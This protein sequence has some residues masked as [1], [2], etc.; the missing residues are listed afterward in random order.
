MKR[1]AGRAVVITGASR[2]LGRAMALA[3]GAEGAHVFVGYHRREDDAAETL[4]L[5]SGAGTGEALR[6]DVTRPE[7][8]DAAFDR[9]H[10]ARG[11]VDVL[12]NNAGS[13]RDAPVTLMDP[14]AWR[15]V[16]AVNLDGAFLCTRAALSP[17][18]HAR[19]GA[20]VN[21]AS[22]AGLRANPGQANY[23][24]SKGGL[25]ALTRTLAAELAPRGIRVNAV[26]PGLIDTG[27]VQRLDHRVRETVLS[28]VPLGRL[29]RA[30]ELARAVLFLASDDAAYVVGC[31]LTVDG[32]L[33]L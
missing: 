13:V 14:P 10:T 21:V 25:L 3:F 22:A 16:L 17:M 5:L 4:R 24:A 7:E 1:F 29:G 15:E 30:E 6:F 28:R 26:V 12:V 2:G 18:I 20:I 9:V 27:M 32:G 23:S 11:R 33:S 31:E 8:V 19:K